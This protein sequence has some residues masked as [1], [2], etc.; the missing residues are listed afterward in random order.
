M[1]FFLKGFHN[2]E[3]LWSDDFEM[4]RISY[5]KRHLGC[6]DACMRVEDCFKNEKTSR[7]RGTGFVCFAIAKQTKSASQREALFRGID[8][9]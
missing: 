1:K 9:A 8:E 2:D 4:R 5:Y 3:L 7:K 6:M